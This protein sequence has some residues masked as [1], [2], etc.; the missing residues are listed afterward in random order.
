LQPLRRTTRTAGTAYPD[1]IHRRLAQLKQ[2]QVA[3][4][5]ADNDNQGGGKMQAQL[6][7]NF[8]NAPAGM[9][10]G[11]KVISGDPKVQLKTQRAMYDLGGVAA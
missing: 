4:A 10:S 1:E 11:L 7:V 2:T 5:K 8:A 6:D 9:T 3:N